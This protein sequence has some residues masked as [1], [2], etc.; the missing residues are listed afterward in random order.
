MN[1]IKAS[2]TKNVMALMA[3]TVASPVYA[4]NIPPTV[5]PTSLATCWEVDS[6]EF[7]VIIWPIPEVSMYLKCQTSYYIRIR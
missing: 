4:I 3:M 2:D 1:W 6:K 5:E 7:A